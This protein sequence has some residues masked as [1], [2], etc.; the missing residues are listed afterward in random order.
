M[1]RRPAAGGAGR[2][3]DADVIVVGAGFGGLGAALRL[4]EEGARVVLLERVGY[5]GGCAATF[6]R[7]GTRFEAGATLL[8]GFGPGQLFRRWIDRHGLDVPVDPLD[9]VLELRAP[10]LDLPVPADREAFVARLAALPGVPQSP[11]RA[12][13]D[14]QRAVADRLWGLF[15][16]PALLLPLGP[17]GLAGHLS[18]LP[19]T[20]SLLPLLG[21]PLGA[22]LASHGLARCAPLRTYVDALCQI[23]VQCTADEA[24]APFALAALDYPFRGAGHVRGGVGTLATALA[25]ALGDLGADVRFHDGVTALRRERDAWCVVSR[26]GIVRA[27]QVVLNL[28]PGAVRALLP[29]GTR[30]APRLGRAERALEDGWGACMLYLV[31]RPP[32]AGAGAPHHLQIVQ[33]PAA[34]PVDG[35]QVFCSVSGPRDEGRA[36]AG[37]RTMTVSTHVSLR[38]LRDLPAAD[39]GGYVDGVQRRMRAALDAHAPE[40]VEDVVHEMTASPRTFER[41]TGRP[42]GSVGGVPRRA[43]LAHYATLSPRPVAPGVWMVGDSVFPGQSALAAALG[44]VK[45][46]EAVLRTRRG[47]G[48]V[49]STP[50]GGAR[51]VNS[52]GRRRDPGLN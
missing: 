46:A 33:D 23:T 24:E 22:L 30:V 45:T 29:E 7:G 37:L 10:G 12:F 11:L 50:A 38:R 49:A 16:D 44:G 8:G 40:W 13:L 3:G 20:L 9:P 14:R 5:P 31:V 15:E 4:A 28:L 25:G 6:M 32:A 18:R 47:R 19:G 42:A 48:R 26:R 17:G 52:G 34:A 2:H 27:P 21:R 35:N 39:V 1:S 51:R 41:F 43:G 36:P